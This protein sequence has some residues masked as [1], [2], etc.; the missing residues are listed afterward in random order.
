MVTE[1][2]IEHNI[3]RIMYSMNLWWSSDTCN[4]D[5][6]MWITTGHEREIFLIWFTFLLKV[7]NRNAYSSLFL[8]PYYSRNILNHHKAYNINIYTFPKIFHFHRLWIISFSKYNDM[9]YMYYKTSG[10]YYSILFFWVIKKI[11]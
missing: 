7:V 2:E 6:I 1:C 5:W 8:C 9:F 3:R 10:K 4:G 11:I